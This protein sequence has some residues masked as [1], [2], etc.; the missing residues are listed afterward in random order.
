[1]GVAVIFLRWG[2][3]RGEFCIRPGRPQGIAPTFHRPGMGIPS[4]PGR[5]L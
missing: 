5:P 4:R 1:M 2:T 3:G